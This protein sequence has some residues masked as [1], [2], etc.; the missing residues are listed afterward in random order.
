MPRLV[1]A[2]TKR[3]R[4]TEDCPESFGS[5]L[6]TQWTIVR[7]TRCFALTA[8]MWSFFLLLASIE[9]DLLRRTRQNGLIES[10]DSTM[11]CD[12]LS[13][14][15]GRLELLPP[16]TELLAFATGLEPRLLPTLAVWILR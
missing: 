11:G 4:P 7:A 6:G 3:G 1:F 14:D 2:E 8:G 13:R 5:P 12:S 9:P 15:I 16:P 10:A